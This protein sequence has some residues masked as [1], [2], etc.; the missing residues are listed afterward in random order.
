MRAARHHPGAAPPARRRPA[1]TRLL[2]A[3]QPPAVDVL[4]IDGTNL[5]CIA[6]RHARP[7]L[8]LAAAASAWLD[9]LCALLR[10]R[11]CV[12]A[13]DNKGSDRRGV[14]AAALPTYLAAR[15]RR[16]DGRRGGG[17]G[18]GGS[19]SAAPRPSS[20]EQL[21]EPLAARGA[22]ALLADG[23][24]EADDALGCLA[25]ALAAAA[26][27]LR[28][29]V[30]SGDADM[31]QLIG[32]RVGWLQLLDAAGAAQPL[33]VQWHDLASFQQA[34]GFAPALHPDY[35]ALAGGLCVPGPGRGVCAGSWLAG[36]GVRRA[37][38]GVYALGPGWQVGVCTGRR[39]VFV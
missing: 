5:A 38:A 39:L 26:P 19:S 16:A 25:R 21:R 17:G 12:C 20:Y 23:G 24:F 27:G 15:H 2:A 9:F 14:R 6:A 35:L 11:H 22:L 32:P 7:G 30:A 37:P 34:W 8:P 18:G 1:A 4:L 28:A 31:R 36:G 3:R 10:P 33:G 29:A 13:F